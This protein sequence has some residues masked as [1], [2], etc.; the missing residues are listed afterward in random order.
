[1]EQ[2]TYQLAP[3][4]FFF[5]LAR[6]LCINSRGV[7]KQRFF[8]LMCI[9]LAPVTDVIK[10]PVVPDRIKRDR[11]SWSVPGALDQRY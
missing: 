10:S 6:V 1:M 2:V 5:V 11:L 3:R 7:K 4:Y 9:D 8:L